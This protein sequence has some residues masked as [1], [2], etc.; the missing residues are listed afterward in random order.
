MNNKKLQVWL[1]LFLSI[2]MIVGMY[3]GY[4]M[5]DT[6]PGKNF[7]SVDKQRP[8]Q[9]ILNLIQNKYVD[10]VKLNELTDT[11]I[12]AMLDKLDPHSVFIPA[13]E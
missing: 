4:K 8:V 12:Q 3:L 1:P 5:R 10:D 13:E 6:M 2:S 7:F 9:E 11:A